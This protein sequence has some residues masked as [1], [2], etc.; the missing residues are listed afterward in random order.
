MGVL[1]HDDARAPRVQAL[2]APPALAERAERQQRHGAVAVGELHARVERR[3]GVGRERVDAPLGRR[4]GARGRRRRRRRLFGASGGAAACAGAGIGAAAAAARRL[5]VVVAALGRRADA[6]AGFGAHEK[7]E[8]GCW[9]QTAGVSNGSQAQQGELFESRWQR[10][11]AN[12]GPAHAH[13]GAGELT[14]SRSRGW[15]P[16]AAA[17]R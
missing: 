16:L 4:L 15:A 3:R 8:A 5:E 6:V 10:N 12:P 2:R 11:R 17:S 7:R 9:K 13:G 14:G 1:P